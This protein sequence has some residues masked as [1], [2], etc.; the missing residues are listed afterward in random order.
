VFDTADH[1]GVVRAGGL[2]EPTELLALAIG[3]AALL[4]D[5]LR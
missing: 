4:G 2:E 5:K 1:D 3:A